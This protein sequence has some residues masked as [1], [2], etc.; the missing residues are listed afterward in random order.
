LGSRFGPRGCRISPAL[1]HHQRSVYANY[2]SWEC[3][4]HS[5]VESGRWA[6]ILFCR[7]C[8]QLL[9]RRK[10]VFK[11]GLVYCTRFIAHPNT[12]CKPYRASDSN[13]DPHVKSIRYADTN[14]CTHAVSHTNPNPDANTNAD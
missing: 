6:D 3:N 2:G 5:G 14:P 13:T 11:S 4:L 9:G 10:R 1:R 8:I 12:D 7:H